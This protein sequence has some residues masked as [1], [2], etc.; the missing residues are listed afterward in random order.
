[1]PKFNPFPTANTVK[2]TQ[3]EIAAK[4]VTEYN[5]LC[6]KYGLQ[7][8]PRM[9]V[10]V[11]VLPATDTAAPSTPNRAARRNKKTK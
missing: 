6:N 1:M 10:D 2:K 3:E 9:I 7:I 4:F 5:A 11:A 8:A